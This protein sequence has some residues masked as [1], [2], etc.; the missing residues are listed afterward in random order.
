MIALCALN[1][2]WGTTELGS[3]NYEGSG[4]KRVSYFVKLE[5]NE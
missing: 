4:Q 3:A 2:L 5:S 1:T